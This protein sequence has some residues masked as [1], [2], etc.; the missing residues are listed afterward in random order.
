MKDRDWP[1]WASEQA[2]VADFTAWA[3]HSG[4]VAYAETEG[5]DI[6]LVRPS[7]DFQIGVEAKMSLNATVVCQVL[8][9]DNQYRRGYGPD[10]RAVLV[11]AAKSVNGMA[12]IC[13]HLG[14]VVIKGSAP[15]SYSKW[16]GAQ[17]EP[18][19]PD[20]DRYSS[21]SELDDY[22]GWPELCPDTRCKLPDYVPDVIGGAPAPVSL[23]HW[24]VKAI[25]LMI[26]LEARGFITRD[27]CKALDI[28]SSRWMAPPFSWLKM[29]EEKGQWVSY[30]EPNFKRQHPTN[31]AQI[32]ADYSK[33][34]AGLPPQMQNLSMMEKP[35]EPRPRRRR[36]PVPE[37]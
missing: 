22:S 33:W 37:G 26:I 21:R 1:G 24:K 13:R 17:F 5:W 36:H 19:L 34:S 3:I 12:T 30:A 29:G 7:D 15:D 18:R 14:I 4:W 9:R 23:S 20:N 32:K 31:Y 2:M 10:C 16:K 8:S 27:D 25:K 11:P 35:L 6:L 28:D